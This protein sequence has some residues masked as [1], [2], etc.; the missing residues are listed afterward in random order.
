MCAAAEDAEDES[1]DAQP[2]AGRD[3]H[4]DGALSSAMQEDSTP[5]WRAAALDGW[6]GDLDIHS[7]HIVVRMAECGARLRREPR[8]PVE[9]ATIHMVYFLQSIE[10]RGT[11]TIFVVSYLERPD[12]P[13]KANLVRCTLDLWA[14]TIEHRYFSGDVI[15]FKKEQKAILEKIF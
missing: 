2:A 15:Y 11:R 4:N 7:R 8:L 10:L 13:I 12:I 1:T 9:R 3:D 6:E 5:S 14:A